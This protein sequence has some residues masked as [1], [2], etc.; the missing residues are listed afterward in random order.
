MPWQ[1]RKVQKYVE[2]MSDHSGAPRAAS[3]CPAL[4]VTTAVLTAQHCNWHTHETAVHA[5]STKMM[6]QKNKIVLKISLIQSWGSTC[7]G[8]E[9]VPAHV[10]LPRPYQKQSHSPSVIRRWISDATEIQFDSHNKVK[11]H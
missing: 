6:D 3:L 5:A 2:S 8:G 4:H 11:A 1:L 7:Q 10:L 9:V